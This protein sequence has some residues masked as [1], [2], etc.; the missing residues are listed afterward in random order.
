M[1]AEKKIDIEWKPCYCYDVI[2]ANDLPLCQ[3][4]CAWMSFSM[5]K[6]LSKLK[7]P[8]K[9]H[10]IQIWS[11]L[12]VD[13]EKK[14]DI[15]RKQCYCYDVI[16]TICVTLYSIC[17][18]TFTVTFYKCHKVQQFWKRIGTKHELEK[19]FSTQTIIHWLGHFLWF[20]KPTKL[21]LSATINRYCPHQQSWLMFLSN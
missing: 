15:K 1:D 5:L 18:I 6:F 20:L 3:F 10:P 11:H 9:L 19:V 21:C 16:F 14:I 17:I 2:F 13:A 4:F 7:W 12:E 8:Y